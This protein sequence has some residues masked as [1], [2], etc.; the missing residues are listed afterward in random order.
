MFYD[1]SQVPSDSG[2]TT[3]PKIRKISPMASSAPSAYRVFP[4]SHTPCVSVTDEYAHSQVAQ[5]SLRQIRVIHR[6]GRH[7][8]QGSH[9]V[10]LRRARA[11]QVSLTIEDTKRFSVA[12]R[13]PAD[14]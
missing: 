8:R 12:R 11:T 4:L 6:Y 5:A 9:P 3:T 14:L 2:V 7:D 10:I 1:I 13:S